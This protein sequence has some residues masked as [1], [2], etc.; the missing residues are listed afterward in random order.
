MSGLEEAENVVAAYRHAGKTPPSPGSKTTVH[1]IEYV[2]LPKEAFGRD[3]GLYVSVNP[4][5]GN[6]N[7]VGEVME[8]LYNN[9]IKPP[10]KSNR[11]MSETFSQQP[12]WLHAKIIAEMLEA[13]LPANPAEWMRA[14][15]YAELHI[16]ELYDSMC[17][18]R[19]GDEWIDMIVDFND[20]VPAVVTGSRVIN[21]GGKY[22]GPYSIRAIGRRLY[23]SLPIE[24][25]N[26]LEWNGM[27]LPEKTVSRFREPD[28]RM[29]YYVDVERGKS[30]AV[31]CRAGHDKKTGELFIA[32]SVY[33]PPGWTM[34][35][36]IR[37]VRDE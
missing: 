15:K 35:K 22:E 13:R 23:P 10:V 2:Y 12:C 18:K 9:T 1:G 20:L 19:S 11:K 6:H 33:S 24:S 4:F 36:N 21:D 26:V 34:G 29:W 31:S 7:F 28:N 32:V 25:C 30:R 16:P 27:G 37:L 8:N 5:Q 17:G 3:R 14:R